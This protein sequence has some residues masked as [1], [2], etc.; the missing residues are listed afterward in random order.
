M[1]VTIK[2]ETTY[3]VNVDG[4]TF[5]GMIKRSEWNGMME[6]RDEQGRTIIVESPP[7]LGAILTNVFGGDNEAWEV[8]L[9]KASPGV[10]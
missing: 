8:D 3:T 10:V 9:V 5:R 6:L 1:R 2:P 7:P 4:K